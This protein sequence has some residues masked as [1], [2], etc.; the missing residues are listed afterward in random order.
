MEGIGQ[1]TRKMGW[2]LPEEGARL[3]A[4]RLDSAWAALGIY[5][6]ESHLFSDVWVDKLESATMLVGR[7]L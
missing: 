6:V 3:Q 5:P 4:N 1:I 2:W 7:H